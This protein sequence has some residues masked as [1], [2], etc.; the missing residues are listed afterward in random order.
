MS[1]LS[2]HYSFLLRTLLDQGG[3]SFNTKYI[4]LNKKTLQIYEIL[5]EI[6]KSRAKDEILSE[7]ITPETSPDNNETLPTNNETNNEPFQTSTSTESSF[8]DIDQI[9]SCST[10]RSSSPLL[11]FPPSPPPSPELKPVSLLSP[12]DTISIKNKECTIS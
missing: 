2:D 7:N 6:E 10:T 3:S 1:L 8:S 4:L 12:L 11:V 9:G 5:I